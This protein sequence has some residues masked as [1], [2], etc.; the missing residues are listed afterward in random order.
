MKRVLIVSQHFPPERSGCAS[1]VHDIAVHLSSMTVEVTV[2]SP[3]PTFPFG[4]F[5]RRWAL[6]S[7]RSVE[8]IKLINLWTIQP[9][10]RNPG[11]IIR[12]L[13]FLTFPLHVTLWTLFHV[14]T[15]DVIITSDPPIFTHIPG[16]IMKKLFKKNW[17]I[18]VRDLWIDASISLG[19][20][21]KGSI[22]EKM[23]RELV[24]ICLRNTDLIGVTT[25]ELGKRLS[26][27]K[28]IQKK[29]IWLPNGVDTTYFHPFNNP[30]KNQIVYAGN[31]G[32][33]QDLEK[34]ILAIKEVNKKFPLQFNIV[35][36]GDING[37]LKDLVK[38]EGMEDLVLFT[39][40]ID[41]E[42]IPMILS[43]SLIGVSPLK[44][45]VTLEY[46]APTK[47]YEYMACGIPFLGC[48]NGEISRIAQQSGAGIIADN[49]PESIAC[50]LEYLLNDP[51]NM[52][53]MGQH[54]RQYVQENY[55]R[56]AVATKINE[57]IRRD[58]VCKTG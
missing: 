5:K 53:V 3:H 1:R 25:Q 12:T 45:L 52:D 49:T 27:D 16:L 11:F 18:E 42:K 33:A 20:I 57:Y 30:K 7:K 13:Y 50:V 46:A 21:K 4:E 56:R 32:H 26:P 23:S 54:G 43:E 34:V 15:F 22:Y 44:K 36:D 29:I 14:R 9:T 37:R 28:T 41:R 58:E 17:T 35:G 31:V 10:S 2:I 39:G 19:F 47:V 55:E 48:G 6:S 51:H 38:S 40:N 8:G 24:N